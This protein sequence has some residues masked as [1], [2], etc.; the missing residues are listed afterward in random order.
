MSPLGEVFEE[1]G[2]HELHLL[3]HSSQLDLLPSH[4]SLIMHVIEGEMPF[5]YHRLWWEK[6]HIDEY[7]SGM[8][9]YFVPYQ[10]GRSPRTARTVLMLR[11]ME[12]FS[13]W[14]YPYDLKTRIRN[15]TLKRMSWHD[16]RHAD[17]VI[18][19]SNFALSYL[20]DRIG[21]PSDRSVT[22]RHGCSPIFCAQPADR[23]VET[24]TALGVNGDYVFTSGSLLPYR[25]LEDIIEAFARISPSHKD[26]LLVVTGG[27]L[28]ASY[29]AK[30]RSA[31]LNSGAANRIVIT[32]S[33][34]V[35]TMAVLY[36]N[37][38][39]FV[40]ASEIEACPN[41]IIEALSS[42]CATIAS[43]R[44]PFP[45]FIGSSGLYFTAR[46]VDALTAI[47]KRVV[48]DPELRNRLKTDARQAS[49]S[50]TWERCARE[51]F[52]TLTVW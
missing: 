1:D 4:S 16:L 44:D 30:I 27:F 39:G 7:V 20:N 48:E 43:R 15:E 52:Q 22:V 3:I 13:H 46:D 51:T 18:A 40:S 32:G 34:P 49:A 35:E 6:Q 42:G 5:S 19:V 12:P 24:L 8:D 29:V 28:N 21:V 37:C 23:D 33:V 9:V 38:I 41:T 17:R 36:R 14:Q 50:Y 45:E 2:R 11:N 10:V 31:V 26:L 47:I 25:R